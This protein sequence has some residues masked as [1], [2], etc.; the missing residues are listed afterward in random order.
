[1]CGIAGIVQTDGRDVS[2]D[3]L[4]RMVARLEH[5]GPDDV[6][7]AF[8]ENWALGHRRLAILDLTNEGHQPMVL[9]DLVL[10]YNGEV[11]NYLELRAE[12]EALGH[13]F[14]SS[15]DTE[16][17][18]HAYQEWGEDCLERFIG[19]WAL[20]LLDQ[21]RQGLFCARDR[22]GIKPFYYARDGGRFLLASECPA[23]LE[24]DVSR[25]VDEDALA[26]YLVTGLTDHDGGTFYAAVRQLP[27]ACRAS[28][29]LNSGSFEV[30]PYYDF[31]AAS[32]GPAASAAEYREVL[33]DSVR[34]RLRS[35]VPVGTCLS[36]GLDSST[37]AALASREARRLGRDRFHA[38]TAGVGSGAP[39]ETAFARRV[40]EHCDLAWDVVSPSFADVARDLEACLFA[41]GEPVGGPSVFL[42]Y[43]VM[44][45]ARERGLK[46]MLDGQGGDESLLGYERY[47][48]AVFGAL[49]RRGQLLRAVR[50]GAGR[51]APERNSGVVNS[52]I[53]CSLI[54]SCRMTRCSS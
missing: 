26:T 36:G 6:G 51:S 10:V 28:L 3:S 43:C 39:D 30:A 11:Y 20:A 19:M 5:R 49:M 14:R 25:R 2:R 50:S 47:Y 16:V 22:L 17:V 32:A 41:Q 27:P 9:G 12:L 29:D 52:V 48:P 1:M 53:L 44:R 33:E 8:G 40:V 4:D 34:L 15:T 13:E 42:Q 37:V 7:R 23:L 21:R 31:A 54:S 35:D 18:L 45:H 38:V 46:V 24:A